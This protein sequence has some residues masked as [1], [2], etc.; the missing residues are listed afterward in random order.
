MTFDDV[1]SVLADPTRR[2]ILEALREE[3]N[4]V[5]DL[6]QLLEVSQPTVS[7]HLKVL[8][9]AG[10]LRMRADGQRR[11]YSV[12]P[13]ALHRAATWLAAFPG[14]PGTEAAVTGLTG[15]EYK[16]DM[17]FGNARDAAGSG[18]GT[19][20]EAT[21]RA[22]E[23]AASYRAAQ[24]RE[25]DGLPTVDATDLEHENPAIPGS[26]NAPQQLGRTVGRTVEQVTGRAQD[27]LERLQ[28]PKFGRRR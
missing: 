12:E 7:K 15:A 4:S 10:V 11:I 18:D 20:E 1:F 6:V 27:L 22:L 16:K 28:K 25:Q 24:Q 26:G 14:H 19:D 2:R 3:E 9:E 21:V 13:G 23:V 8:R 5:G 17:A